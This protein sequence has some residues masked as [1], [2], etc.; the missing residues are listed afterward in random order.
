MLASKGGYS[1]EDLALVRQQLQDPVFFAQNV[2]GVEP[3]SRQAEVLRAVANNK[4][5]SV[6]SGHKVSKSNSLAILALWWAW[7]K[8]DARVAVTSA[9]FQQV[10]KI[11]WREINRMYRMSRIPLGGTMYRDPAT[12]LTFDNFNEI[13]GFSTNEPERAAGISSPNLLYLLDEASG[14]PEEL[15]EA[16]EG[17]RAA[18][19]SMVMFSNPT[20]M[21]GTFF[22]SFH[23]KRNFWKTIHISSSDSPNVT[24]ERSI[25]GLATK[26]WID[27]KAEEWGVSS[28]MYQVRVLGNFPGQGSNSVIGLALVSEANSRYDRTP[29]GGRLRIGVDVARYGDDETVIYPVRGLR[30]LTPLILRNADGPS[31]AGNV[32]NLIDKLRGHVDDEIRVKVD[33]IGLGASPVD[34]LSVMERAKSS[35]VVVRAVNVADAADESDK[36]HDLRTQLCFDLKKW[37]ELGGAVH[38]D[39]LLTQE[40]VSATYDF[41]ARGRMRLVSKKDEKKLMG[42]SP[43]RRNALELALYEPKAK[44]SINAAYIPI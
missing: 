6:R 33:T 10:E 36:Y 5:V 11:I 9:S 39:D 15:F 22:D 21:T 13:F 16:M 1:D 19:A 4:R 29:A 31:V 32:L 37:L 18:G 20:R 7:T 3:W 34:F 26:E 17:N 43:D 25:P 30:A 14:I 12:G 27:E 23:A 28:P 40:L 35:G 24:G 2:L 41:D 44:R 38:D 8:T 42:R